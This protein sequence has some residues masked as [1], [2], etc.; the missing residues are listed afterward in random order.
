MRSRLRSQ[1]TGSGAAGG[2]GLHFDLQSLDTL[3]VKVARLVTDSRRVQRGDTFLAYHGERQ[4]GRRFIPDAIK[5]GANAVLWEPQGFDWDPA[6]RVPN[7]PVPRLRARAGLI[8][9]HVYGDPSQ[10]LWVI[11]ITG[12]NGKTSTS[13]WIAQALTG[14]GRRTLIMGT[15]GLGFPGELEETPNTTPDAVFIHEQMKQHLDLGASA[16]TMEV[17]SHALEQGRVN[18]VAF[19]LALFTNLSRDHLDYH[20]T[21]LAY[22]EAKTRLFHFPGLRLG[23]L[24]LDDAFGRELLAR[25][26]RDGVPVQGYGFEESGWHEARGRGV[27]LIKGTNL[28][29]TERGIAFDVEAPQGRARVESPML[30]RFN[31]ANLLAC[32]AVLIAS[33]VPLAQAVA[34][35]RVAAPVAGRMEQLGGGE[36]P[37][38]V[39]DYAHTPDAL[40][41]ALVTLR[42]VM[43][44]ERG[45][46]AKLTCVFGCGG[47]RDKGKRPLMGEVATR[48]ADTVI[49][50]SDNPRSENPRRIIDDIIAG[51]HAN[52]H[53][54]EDRAAAVYRAIGEA[55]RGDVVLIAGKGHE[56][57]Q[58]IGGV[59][60]PFS[61]LEVARLALA[62]AEARLGSGGQ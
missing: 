30:G 27:P 17:S 55:R 25:L 24:N 43:A 8:A 9:S 21:M 15:L 7:L 53:V 12:T 58:E 62:L 47:D 56:A 54:E 39:V 35:L 1:E 34:A 26:S 28:A 18:G 61:D 59:K 3:G 36:L 46:D 60:L 51:I 4:D 16:L 11:G 19:D 22:A 48:L 6:W 20:G 14:V 23:I 33:E 2:H 29:L 52:Y 49:L 40:E 44:G 10:E 31:A 38:V 57:Y 45:R 37:L 13:H 41:K 32:V 42:E 5:A 50:T